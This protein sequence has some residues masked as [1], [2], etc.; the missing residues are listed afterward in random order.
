[1]AS[2]RGRPTPADHVFAILTDFAKLTD[3]PAQLK[4][5]MF[6]FLDEPSARFDDIAKLCASAAAAAPHDDPPEGYLLLGWPQTAYW[7]DRTTLLEHRY[8]ATP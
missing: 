2:V 7:K 8:L 1:M 5:M 4:L 3:V 6:A